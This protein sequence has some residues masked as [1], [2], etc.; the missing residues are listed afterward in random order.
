VLERILVVGHREHAPF[1]LK[2]AG[3]SCI[4]AKALPGSFIAM[5]ST[6]SSLLESA[7]AAEAIQEGDQVGWIW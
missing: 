7:E 1:V 5:D 6:R 3:I 2:V 4:I